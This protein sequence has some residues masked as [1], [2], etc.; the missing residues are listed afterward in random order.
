MLGIGAEP[1]GFKPPSGEGFRL[2]G[3]DEP[4]H[5]PLIVGRAGAAEGQGD[6][7]EGEREEAVSSWA[8]H[9][10]V[11]LGCG[12]GEQIDLA[13]VQAEAL[14][15]GLHHRLMGAL[16]GQKNL[17]RAAVDQRRGNG[18]LL[19]IREA[20]GGKEDADIL[21]PER[22]QPGLDLRCEKAVVEK[23]PSLIQN[24]KR[25][26]AGER[27]L[28]PMK[29]REQGRGD[30]TRKIG[31]R[32]QIETLPIRTAPCRLG[33][34]EQRAIGAFEG[35]GL[36][37][38]SDFP[39]LDQRA[40]NGE[41]S[42]LF[43]KAGERAE[44]TPK[45]IFPIDGERHTFLVQEIGQPIQSKGSFFGLIDLGEWLQRHRRR[46]AEPAEMSAN[47]MAHRAGGATLVE[48]DHLGFRIAKELRRQECKKGRF[49]GTGRPDQHG[50]TDIAGM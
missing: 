16:V 10:V 28:Q 49:A 20:L 44:S 5:Q 29:D 8:H 46:V 6:R 26:L 1:F 41:R 48:D 11:A 30:G 12:R 3:I 33:G 17:L 24:Q 15:E 38:L 2:V 13:L 4:I 18:A 22:L 34:I 27:F 31:Q 32:F 45:R 42:L 14:I 47:G 9:V 19:D 40:Q 35:E 50:M 21:F 25:R 23:E 39:I 37:R 7:T 43:L 36:K